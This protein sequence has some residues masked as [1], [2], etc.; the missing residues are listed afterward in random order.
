MA[1]AL[2][3]PTGSFELRGVAEGRLRMTATHPDYVP[4]EIAVEFDT[5]KG[6]VETRLVLSRGGR[7]EGVA[8]RRDGTPL[9]RAGGR[10]L[11][12]DA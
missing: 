4:P 1:Q 2:T 5:L 3:E 10:P 11:L 12:R 9:L 8:H 7:I 6:P